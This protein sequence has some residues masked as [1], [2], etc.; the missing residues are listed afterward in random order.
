MVTLPSTRSSLR[1]T[2]RLMYV[3]P[4]LGCGWGK[5]LAQSNEQTTIE[6]KTT[7]DTTTNNNDASQYCMGHDHVCITAKLTYKLFW[8]T[9]LSYLIVLNKYDIV[10]YKYTSQ[11]VIYACAEGHIPA[12][13]QYSCH[14]LLYTSVLSYTIVP[15]RFS[16]VIGILYGS[17]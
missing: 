7:W 1:N 6:I 9:A 3:F 11:P 13:P 17:R 8:R 10:V 12:Y 4:G 16:M 2:T 15:M 5:T 14:E